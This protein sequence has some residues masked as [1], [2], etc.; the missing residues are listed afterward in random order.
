MAIDMLQDS[1]IDD[2]SICLNEIPI[3]YYSNYI[4]DIDLDFFRTA[5][6]V[7]PNNKEVFYHLIRQSKIIT[8]ATEPGYIEKGITADYLLNKI[9]YHIEEAMK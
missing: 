9:L 6:S 3:D 2:L 5:K 4:L 8:I 1:N 7:N